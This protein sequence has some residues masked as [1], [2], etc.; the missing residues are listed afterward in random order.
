M[1]REAWQ[2]VLHEAITANDALFN[3]ASTS[4]FEDHYYKAIQKIAHVEALNRNIDNSTMLKFWERFILLGEDLPESDHDGYAY[5]MSSNDF[6]KP[7]RHSNSQSS[8]V[9]HKEENTQN[10]TFHALI[11]E[12]KSCKRMLATRLNIAFKE[13]IYILPIHSR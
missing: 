8:L 11:E 1:N 5:K 10:S 12:K 13:K 9:K 7:R 3:K 2:H 6:Y 4:N